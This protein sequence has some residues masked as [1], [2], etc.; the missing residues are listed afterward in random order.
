MKRALL[1]IACVSTLAACSTSSSTSTTSV[2]DSAAVTDTV[3]MSTT[4]TVA[5]TTATVS[6]IEEKIVECDEDV[7]G[8]DMKTKVKMERCTDN[9]GIGNIDKNTWNCPD[10]GCREASLFKRANGKWST[11]TMC[12]KD[13]PMVTPMR[14]C[15]RTDKAAVATEDDVF[16]RKLRVL[17]GKP[18]V[19]CALSAS[20]VVSRAQQQSRD[21]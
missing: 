8:A 5:I 19:L 7:I 1:A 6:A 10:N 21:R 16:P 14:L 13:Q 17:C 15:Y 4:T 3:D 12:R 2:V 9:F 18:I 11:N 20:P